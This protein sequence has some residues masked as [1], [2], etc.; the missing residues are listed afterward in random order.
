MKRFRAW[1]LAAALAAPAVAAP[2]ALFDVPTGFFA[3]YEANRASGTP[4]Y[5]TEDFLALTYA[6]L[7]ENAAT[8]FERREALPALRELAPSLRARIGSETEP[9]RLAQGFLAVFEALLLGEAPRDAPDG[10][11]AAR[12]LELVRGARGVARSPLMRQTLDYSQ[13]RVRGK[14]TASEALGRYFRAVRYAG[15]VLFPL[16]HSRSTGI[17]AEAADALTGAALAISAA[18]SADDA[19]RALY[20]RATGPLGYLFGPPDALTVEEYAPLAPPERSRWRVGGAELPRLRLSLFARG[21]RP[22]VLG[23]AV[24]VNRLEPGVAPADALA[25]WQF[26]PSRLAPESAVFQELVYDRVGIY[27]GA[28]RPFTLGTVNGRPVKAFPT[29]WELAALLGSDAAEER[30]RAAGDTDY[31]GYAEARQ[32]AAEA[33][34]LQ[35][36]LAAEHFGLLRA[37]LR[38]DASD[39]RGPDAERRLQTALGF[40]ALQRHGALLYAKQ[41]YTQTAK[42]LAPA[43]PARALAWIAP[44]EPLY[45]ELGR[46]AREVAERTGYEPLERYAGLAERCAGLAR[47]NPPGQPVS[48]ADADFLNGLDADLLDLTGRPDQPVVADYHTDASSGQAVEIALGAPRVATAGPSGAERGRGA[49]FG[50]HQFKQPLAKRH[51]DETWARLVAVSRAPGRLLATEAP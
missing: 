4:N 12:E 50:V 31:E 7:V 25:G 30:L 38:P 20:E 39:E 49:L 6:M 18:V 34:R 36:G 45:T 11:S 13:F 23:A 48:G 14:Y 47:G 42:G 44:A 35:T 1:C 29:V 8:E 24:D 16:L 21:V 41:S 32:R 40:W 46:L 28:G 27:R 9:E 3:V 15:A 51:T 2:L 33:L 43:P 5:V 17:G 26:L 37:W 22:R 10:E 19:T